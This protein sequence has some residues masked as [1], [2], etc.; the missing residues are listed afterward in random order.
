[1][2]V[3]EP[4]VS[5]AAALTIGLVYEDR[6]APRFDAPANF[7]AR[8]LKRVFDLVAVLLALP[9]V[10]PVIATLAMLIRID[11]GSAFYMQ[12]RVGRHG[13]IFRFWKLR[14]M[15]PDADRA[16]AAHLVA[17]PAARAEWDATQKLKSDPRIT[18]IGRFI[19]KTSLDAL[20]Q[21]W[22]VLRGDMS[23]VGPRPMLPEQQALYPGRA[24]YALRPG[25]TGF[26]QIGDRN[27]TTFS[28]RAVY[29]TDYARRLSF[30]TDLIVLVLTVR[31]VARGTGY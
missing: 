29:D 25:L 8:R 21:L 18:R 2:H 6:S 17:T 4:Q 27:Q 31:A 15:T 28:D 23:L 11:G 26:W 1:M 5:R 9:V 30:V 22:N 24:Y 12:D 10:L 3:P 20:P 16:L 7:Y 19:R 13:R 14:S